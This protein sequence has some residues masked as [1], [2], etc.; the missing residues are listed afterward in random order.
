MHPRPSTA[1]RGRVPSPH[2]L[3]C[4]H[5]CTPLPADT[6]LCRHPSASDV[7]PA[8]CICMVISSEA[9]SG[10]PLPPKW[11]RVLPLATP[12]SRASPHPSIY[13]VGLYLSGYRPL[14]LSSCSLRADQG[15]VVSI[16]VPQGPAQGLA[17]GGALGG[18]EI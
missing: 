3:P 2:T 17:M 4:N 7:L 11:P 16:S 10:Y 5:R 1:S 13:T 12:A 8:F 18:T 14:S 6:G 15:H 9:F